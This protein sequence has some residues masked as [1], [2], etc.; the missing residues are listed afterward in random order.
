VKG[1]KYLPPF[2]YSA[3]CTILDSPKASIPL[4]HLCPTNTQT[5][6]VVVFSHGNGCDLTHSMDFV[7]ALAE[8][9]KAEYVAYDYT[10]YGQS[11]I[12]HTSS[13]SLCNDL[14]TVL[15]WLDRPLNEVTL[16]GF[17]LGCFP[18]AQ[19]A[20]K[21][22]VKGVVLLAPMMSLFSLLSDP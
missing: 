6:S 13:N 12:K 10:G 7:C 17:S 2:G 16:V 21:Y 11:E 20:S 5:K 22:R 9:H 19:V 18:S 4:V 3:R 14:E 8:K 1:V 15:A